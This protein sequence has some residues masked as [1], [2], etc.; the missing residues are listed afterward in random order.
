MSIKMKASYHFS[1]EIH[2]PRNN[3]CFFGTKMFVPIVGY[4]RPC[5]YHSLCLGLCTASSVANQIAQ[6]HTL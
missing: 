5:F 4:K 6:S 1:T 3:H 2:L